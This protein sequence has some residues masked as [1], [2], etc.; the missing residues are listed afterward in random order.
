MA[1][2]QSKINSLARQKG[3]VKGRRNGSLSLS[4]ATIIPIPEPPLPPVPPSL[5][6]FLAFEN[7]V[8]TPVYAT[9]QDNLTVLDLD[10]AS[11]LRIASSNDIELTGIADTATP[12]KVLVVLNVGT[13]KVKIKNNNAGS[14]A[15]NRFLCDG[16]PNMKSNQGMIFIYDGVSE[17][18]RCLGKL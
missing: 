11:V 10:T 6:S 18:W 7:Y 3:L 17:R 8:N 15:V 16:D 12:F 2:D 4:L 9:D 14:L 5:L 13:K 1:I